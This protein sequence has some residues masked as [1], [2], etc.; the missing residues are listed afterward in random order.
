[1]NSVLSA[2]TNAAVSIR[3]AAVSCKGIDNGAISA[4]IKKLP[5]QIQ[6]KARQSGLK[7]YA[8]VNYIEAELEAM[9]VAELKKQLEIKKQRAKD[10]QI[11][12]DE[13]QDVFDSLL[14]R[15]RKNLFILNG[16]G[17][18]QRQLLDKQFNAQSMSSFGL[19]HIKDDTTLT[20]NC[21][22]E[23]LNIYS[24]KYKEL[25]NEEEVAIAQLKDQSVKHRTYSGKICHDE[26][27]T[28]PLASSTLDSFSG[29][30]LDFTS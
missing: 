10:R 19:K 24:K 26:T 22:N 25:L 12:A 5:E 11:W 27:T 17:S 3:S 9:R 20:K 15:S 21:A 14:K 23:Y 6:L 18:T 30:K 7:G 4:A 28:N 29:N 1:M 2:L 13:A 16:T 8:L